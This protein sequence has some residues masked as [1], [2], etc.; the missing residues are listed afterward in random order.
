MAHE[1]KSDVS[2]PVDG[3]SDLKKGDPNSTRLMARI[4]DKIDS[5][6]YAHGLE[7]KDD[8]DFDVFIEE[9]AA[10]IYRNYDDDTGGDGSYDPAAPPDSSSGTEESVSV[11]LD[12]A[13]EDEE[14]PEEQP[15]KPERKAGGK[16]G[17]IL[18]EAAKQQQS[19]RKR[20]SDAA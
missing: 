5:T 14:E 15:R 17:K 12:G 11:D 6:L 19:K 3:D 8:C 20:D 10:L 18:D 2:E 1:R 4:V 9:L 13:E 16:L 7:F